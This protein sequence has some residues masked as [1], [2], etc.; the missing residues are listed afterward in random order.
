L[1]ANITVNNDFTN[2]H[3]L[4]DTI[5]PFAGTFDANLFGIAHTNTEYI[6]D[7]DTIACGLQFDALDLHSG[8]S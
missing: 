4:A 2:I 1:D 7:A 8:L 6:A 5:E 3:G